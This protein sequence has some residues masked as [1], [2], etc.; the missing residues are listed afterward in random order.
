MLKG[1][2]GVC[3]GTQTWLLVCRN[4][5]AI[6]SCRPLAGYHRRGFQIWQSRFQFFEIQADLK[7]PVSSPST[8]VEQQKCTCLCS[9][10]PGLQFHCRKS[11]KS[12]AWRK[13]P[14]RSSAALAGHYRRFCAPSSHVG[15]IRHNVKGIVPPYAVSTLP[16]PSNTKKPPSPQRAESV[17]KVCCKHSPSHAIAVKLFP[18][19]FFRHIPGCS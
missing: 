6:T 17:Q 10:L 9:L 2:L 8:L 12:P 5:V 13:L 16:Q 18:F 3:H 14:R 1:I 7:S 11:A 19:D 4:V 15:I